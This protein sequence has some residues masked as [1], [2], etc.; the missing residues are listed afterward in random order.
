MVNER[1]N[2][3]IVKLAKYLYRVKFKSL[4]QD[5]GMLS[6]S[7][8]CTSYIKDGKLY[9]NL[10]WNYD[11]GASFHII[12]PDFKGMAFLDGLT[13]TNLD[14][15]LIE[16]LPYHVCDGVSNHGIMVATH[17]LFN[18]W[19]AIGKGSIPL[20]KLPYLVLT[21]VESMETI[22]E[23]LDG[24]L[25][26]LKTSSASEAPV[27]LIQV[28][29]SDGK[30]T[31]LL[32]PK[33]NSKCEYEIVDISSNPKLTNFRWVDKTLVVRE[34]LQERPSGVERWNLLPSDLSELRF[35]KAYEAPNRLSEFIGVKGTTKDSSDDEL[36]KVYESAR[37]LYS[38]RK[39]DGSTWQTMHSVVYSP[40]GME[41]LW[42]QEDW[43]HDYAVKEDPK[44]AKEN[45]LAHYGILGM[46]WGVRRYQNK[47]GSLTTEGKK[48]YG[49]SNDADAGKRK[50]PDQIE[51][52]K[53]KKR[54]V[55]NR[56]TFS[57]A[58]LKEK[59]ERLKMEKELRE[60]TKSEISPGRKFVDEILMEVG[61]RTL[62]TVLTGAALYGTKAVVSK[63]FDA[64][65]FA[66][67]LYNGGPK[68]K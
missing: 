31:C 5:A 51:S 19:N 4:A 46:K 32:R 18:D 14:S 43:E 67:S 7:G 58:E 13:D 12:C 1:Q 25:N 23:D 48:R 52:E 38:K 8:K 50:S 63:E 28:I 20:T 27:Y 9:R 39:R 33:E 3:A 10:D 17:V 16:Q 59:I 21:R 37:E 22:K 61:K 65:E 44:V 60:L 54:D 2:Y 47:D 64:K 55:K 30:T 40:K 68:K 15:A 41:H 57:N 6:T 34:T 56:G 53:Q 35:T 62:T 45:V 36:M 24:V 42:I 29:V 49:D 66:E 26:D 11:E